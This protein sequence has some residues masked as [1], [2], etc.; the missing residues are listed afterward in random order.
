M[1]YTGGSGAAALQTWPRA[2]ARRLDIS[3]RAH[4]VGRLSSNVADLGSV[5]IIYVRNRTQALLVL[6]QRMICPRSAVG[7]LVRSSSARSAGA[8][9]VTGRRFV[10]LW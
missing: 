9:L 1:F 5:A 4:S 8:P 10:F 6:L 7:A 2:A 3:R